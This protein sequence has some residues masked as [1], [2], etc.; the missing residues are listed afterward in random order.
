MTTD[1]IMSN[2]NMDLKKPL[3]NIQNDGDNDPLTP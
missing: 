3:L 2:I 1:D